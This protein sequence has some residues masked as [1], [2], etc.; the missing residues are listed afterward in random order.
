MPESKENIETILSTIEEKKIVIKDAAMTTEELVQRVL[1]RPTVVSVQ[2]T[3]KCNHEERKNTVSEYNIEDLLKYYDREFI[4]I[5]YQFVLKRSPDPV[6]L[7][8]HLSDLR[9][10][11][12]GRVELAFSFMESPEAKEN[13]PN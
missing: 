5:L 8:K 11:I 1:G 2:Q 6:G 9:S 4:E 12:I 13:N 3:E 10:G 7:Q